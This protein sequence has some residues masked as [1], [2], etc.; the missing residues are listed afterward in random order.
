M[1]IKQNLMLILTRDLLAGFPT[2]HTHKQT[3]FT[4]E[5]GHKINLI[6]EQEFE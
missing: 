3:A 2:K 5:I 4:I 1:Q 6:F